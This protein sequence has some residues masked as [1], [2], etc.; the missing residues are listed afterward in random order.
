MVKLSRQLKRWL[1]YIA[2]LLVV[3]VLSWQNSSDSETITNATVGIVQKISKILGKNLEYSQ[4]LYYLIR[5]LGHGLVFTILAYAGHLAINSSATT[6][7]ATVLTSIIMS[8]FIALMAEF[9]QA[10]SFGR[11]A[12]FVDAGINVAG[13]L[14][15]ILLGIIVEWIRQS[16]ATKK[17][18]TV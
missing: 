17:A 4:N 18:K 7:R 6:L 14:V 12:S 15:G 16:I 8:V 13:T 3:F 9:M 11:K 2:I 1:W 10:Y 5:K